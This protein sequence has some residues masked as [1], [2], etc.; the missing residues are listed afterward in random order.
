MLIWEK[1][2]CKNMKIG[3]G[4]TLPVVTGREHVREASVLRKGADG[5]EG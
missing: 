3:N 5:S 1:W 2:L 4:S